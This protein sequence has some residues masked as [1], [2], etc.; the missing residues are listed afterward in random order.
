MPF[1]LQRADNGTS[2]CYRCGGV[3]S[4][5]NAEEIEDLAGIPLSRRFTAVSVCTVCRSREKTQAPLMVRERLGRTPLRWRFAVTYG[6]CAL[7]SLVAA[8]GWYWNWQQ[9]RAAALDPMVGDRW[10]INTSTW[11]NKVFDGNNLKYTVVRV[12]AIY[13]NAIGLSACSLVSDNTKTVRDACHTFSV[14]TYGVERAKLAD[15][16][17]SDAIDTV[18]TDRET[19]GP[20]FVAGAA[21]AT[22]IFAWLLLSER[23]KKRVAIRD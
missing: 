10:T 21:V 2:T 6:L 13:E 20:V 8:F 11:P 5:Y 17:A 15:L 14:G 22:L 23:W 7:I 4:H 19:W 16:F 1:D 3:V 18:D 12:D 9:Q